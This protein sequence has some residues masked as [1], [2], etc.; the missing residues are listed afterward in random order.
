M[1]RYLELLYLYALI[2]YR[3]IGNI[4]I[5]AKQLFTQVPST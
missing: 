3:L 5:S 2:H 4:S 1:L